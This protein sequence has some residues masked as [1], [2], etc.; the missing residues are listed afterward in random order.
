MYARVTNFQC[1]PARIDDMAK[2]VDAVSAEI[3]KVPGIQTAYAVWRGDGAG[4]VTAIYDSE[5]SAEAAAPK[6]K[7]VW[8]SM[9]DYLAAPP[10]AE[11][12]DSV[13]KMA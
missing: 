13:T 7:E 6:V 9:S 5:A 12:Y 8:G 4:V 2:Q 1:D 10:A 11:A 3:A